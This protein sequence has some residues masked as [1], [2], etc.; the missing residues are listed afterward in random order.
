MLLIFSGNNCYYINYDRFTYI[1]GQTYII[2]FS[3][4]ALVFVFYKMIRRFITTFVETQGMSTADVFPQSASAVSTFKNPNLESLNWLHAVAPCFPVNG[5]NIHIIQEPSKFYEI[6]L[7]KCSTAKKRITFVS[8]YLGIGKL[9]Q[10]LVSA[11]MSNLKLNSNL[12]INILLD[13]T[14]GTRGAKNSQTTLHDLIK[15]SDNFC[16]SL[17]HTPALRGLTKRFAPS[18]WNELF[19]LQHMKLYMFDDTV[20]IS[21]AN[22]SNDYF[23]NRQDRY[24]MI[25]DKRLADF[26]HNLVGKVQEFSLKVNH[27]NEIGLHQDWNLLPYHGDRENF[28]VQAKNR[29]KDLFSQYVNQQNHGII[30]NKGKFK[31]VIISRRTE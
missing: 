6:L 30:N 17:Y 23:T 22:L 8:L 21:G 19:G 1:T 5:K 27:K 14:R 31:I 24:V 18:R 13:F 26:Y 20:I 25:E 3:L 16:L 9:E 4:I 2:F 10:N 12:K 15:H 11:M 28:E 29:I 7:S